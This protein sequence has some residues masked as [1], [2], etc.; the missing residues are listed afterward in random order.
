[1]SGSLA[2]SL[3]GSASDPPQ[4]AAIDAGKNYV[5]QVGAFRELALAQRAVDAIGLAQLRIV[6]TSRNEQ[7]WYVLVLGA[8]AEREDALAAGRAYL[9]AYPG[10][11]TWV[12][13]AADLKKSR[14][15]SLPFR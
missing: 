4:P 7:G 14:I 1:M 10:G 12:R 15:S 6:A 9:N 3:T 2:G 5:L 13:A 11:V 8:Y